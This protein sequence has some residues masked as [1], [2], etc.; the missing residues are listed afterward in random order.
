MDLSEDLVQQVVEGCLGRRKEER[1][2]RLE[3][4]KTNEGT[5]AWGKSWQENLPGKIKDLCSTW[6]GPTMGSGGACSNR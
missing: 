1:V 6:P 4:G 2:V 5:G 3:E